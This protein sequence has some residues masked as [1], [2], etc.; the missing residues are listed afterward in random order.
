LPR[1]APLLPD[2]SRRSP[3]RRAAAALALGVT[4]VTATLV[5]PAASAQPGSAQPAPP[6][7]ATVALARLAELD[8]ATLTLGEQ[9]TAAQGVL[10]ARRSELAASDAAAK[11][12]AATAARARA[13]A[14]A[15]RGQVDG[16]VSAAFQGAR[17]SRLTAVLVSTSPQDLLDRMTGLNLLGQDSVARLS[18]ATAARDVAG[19]AE[20][21]A[22][23]ARDL[24][25]AA[26]QNALRVQDDLV[27]RRGELQ[28]QSAEA[29]A[30][31]GRLTAEPGVT[32]VPGAAE[33]LMLSRGA[34]V[35]RAARA[36]ATRQSLFAQ[37][38]VGQ[39]TS[40]Y[41][42]RSGGFHN[43]V[44]IANAIG[45]PVL[46]IA[47]GTV[48]DAGPA[49][50]F[51]LWVRVRHDDGTVV[52]YGHIDSFSV[53]VGQPVAA[54]EQIA[55]MGNRGQSTGPHLHVEITAPGGQRVDPQAWLAA[56]G[57]TV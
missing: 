40:P 6:D 19:R 11:Q 24:A 32:G 34:N 43:G 1:S 4:T 33:Q 39:V 48:I 20:S 42:P 52:I 28:K 51:G 49:A 17:T 22:A 26:E 9:I 38:T 23:S 54:G 18:S 27:V 16:L 55:R 35:Q 2:P 53:R 8:A 57:V 56:R 25:A 15:L 13:D 36:A 30:L 7:G 21:A 10:G 14:D 5:A 46:S 50:G 44:D 37:P 41:G 12:A 3:W 47:D 29:T 31:L 45:T